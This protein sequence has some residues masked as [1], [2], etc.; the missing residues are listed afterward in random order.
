MEDWVVAVGLSCVNTRRLLFRTAQHLRSLICKKQ[1]KRRDRMCLTQKS[2]LRLVFL[3]SASRLDARRSHVAPPFTLSV[4]LSL[5]LA[6]S[7][8]WLSAYRNG[9]I[10]TNMQNA[11]AHARPPRTAGT[12]VVTL[13]TW[14]QGAAGR[15]WGGAATR[16][17]HAQP[18]QWNHPF[19][20]CFSTHT[21]TSGVC[22]YESLPSFHFFL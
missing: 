11:E 6:S 4:P 17:C 13:Q 19:T 3:T 1:A 9:R 16:P 14:R 21:R 2:F 8:P 12:S 15:G 20:L 10:Y 5:L 7:V 22:R 18:L